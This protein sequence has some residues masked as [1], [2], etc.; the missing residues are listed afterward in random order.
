MNTQTQ[1]HTHIPKTHTNKQALLT[2]T[3]YC[4]T[5]HTH[6]PKPA[7]DNQNRHLHKTLAPVG[8]P[9][10][11][12]SPDKPPSPHRSISRLTGHAH[13]HTFWLSLT[14]R[15]SNRP[16]KGYDVN[17]KHFHFPITRTQSNSF[18]LSF[19]YHSHC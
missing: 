12:S 10:N 8:E 5:T 15:H 1:T 18:P 4:N 19:C 17:K 7:S 13:P 6:T 3:H 9:R 16:Q 11:T 14:G 2:L